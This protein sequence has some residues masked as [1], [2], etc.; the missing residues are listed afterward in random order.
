TQLSEQ[1]HLIVFNIDLATNKLLY[2]NPYFEQIFPFK[3]QDVIA[4]PAALLDS[5]HPEDR[6][7]LVEICQQLRL[8]Q[9]ERERIVEFR[10]QHPNSSVL[11]LRLISFAYEE[12]ERNRKLAGIIA[13]ITNEK[14]NSLVLNKITAKKNAVMEIVSHDLTRPFANIKGLISLVRHSLQGEGQEEVY[15]YLEHINQVCKQ[16]VNL[17]RDYV[18]QEMI[19]TTEVELL[20]KKV[21]VVEQIKL[22]M[23]EYQESQHHIHK[24]FQFETS[25]EVINMQLD[26]IK[27]MQALNNLISNAIKFTHD[28]GIIA[29]RVTDQTDTVLF[30]VEDDGVG[31]PKDLQNNL[32]DKDSSAKRPG[33]K[34]EPSTGKGMFYIKCITDWHNGRIWYESEENQGTTFCVEIPKT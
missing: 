4:N 1:S 15:Q 3:R 30:V 24:V 6:D 34:G 2:L 11:W 13:N 29:V 28:N 18:N 12:D 21:D 26:D 25:H 33:L 17:I 31:I 19:D 22:T 14:E 10:I 27:F 9:L 16:A 32:F 5:I 20:K 23:N 8:G 7:Y